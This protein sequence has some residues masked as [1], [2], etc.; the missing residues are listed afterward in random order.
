VLVD[1]GEAALVELHSGGIESA[2]GPELLEVHRAHRMHDRLRSLAEL[3]RGDLADGRGDSEPRRS[4][5]Q[6]GDLGRPDQRL[7]RECTPG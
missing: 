3:R 5:R 2:A 1:A 7:G 6:P 4:A